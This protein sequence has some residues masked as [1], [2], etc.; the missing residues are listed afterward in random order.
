MK[1]LKNLTLLLSLS[2]GSLFAHAQ[3][4]SISNEL[5]SRSVDISN[6]KLAT[7]AIN[8]SGGEKSYVAKSADFSFYIDDERYD[9]MSSW[10]IIDH[11]Q[12]TDNSGM[13]L[14]TITLKDGRANP[15]FQIKLNYALYPGLPLIRKW[16]DFENIGNR[17]IKIE[18]LNVEDLVTT[19][20][21]V[22]SV[23]HHNYARMK[24]LMKYE[25]DW[26][27][28]VAVVHNTPERRG[29]ALGNEAPMVLK[30][31]TYHTDN[32]NIEIGL[33]RSDYKYPFRK[34]LTP[35]QK[36]SSPKTFICLYS[37]QEDGF[38]VVN[39]D[40]NK[41]VTNFMGNRVTNLKKKPTFVYNT[42]YPFRSFI[43]DKLVRDIAKSAAEC[44][45]QEFVIDDG[46]Q[47]NANKVSAN[48]NAGQNY[49]DWLVDLN[50]FPE[51]LKPTF[52]YIK[53]L[54]MKPGLWLSL[55]SA[56]SDSQVFKDHPE[57]FVKDKEGNI[58]NL[59]SQKINTMYTTS[60]GTEWV[61]YI[62]DVILRLVN[63]HG[64]EYAKLDLAIA[65]SA[66]CNDDS[67]T[68]SYST[69]D[70][71]YRDRP[72]SFIVFYENLL[73]LFDDLHQEAPDLFID[74]TFETAGKTQLMDYAISKHAEGN[75]LSNFE[76]NA[77]H[78]SLRVR[79]MAW[80]RSPAL[81][82]S[83]LVIGNMAMDDPN[84]EL[85]LKSLIGSLPIVLGDPRELSASEK[86]NIKKWAD[87]MS[88]MQDKHDYMKFRKDLKGFGEP[89]E[90]YWDGWQRL[91]FNSF[92]GGVFG[93]FRQG[94][95]E[96]SRVVVLDDLKPNSTY[97]VKEAPTGKTIYTGSGKSLME[98]GF[99]VT[100]T[101][102]YD[103]RIFE[104]CL[105]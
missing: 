66:Y 69:N 99:T 88:A 57:W 14:T 31:T 62:K 54:G 9:G 71:D 25:G 96:S 28:A 82:A 86:K 45:I 20:F 56:N 92:E 70:P 2:L 16:I 10:N 89:R 104:V 64:L 19:L 39:N 81:P 24:H 76:G 1:N 59:H 43:D 65:T 13:K 48:A 49:G 36:W 73:K 11:A 77:P 61:D 58:A 38:Q 3:T 68:G 72:E 33:T 95:A 87:W 30:R 6:N 102:E 26:D 12:T 53:S 18:N 27:D 8:L 5:V 47:Y 44:G 103:G 85:T 41:F 80:W 50:K 98:K 67:H 94:G 4:L 37:N 52:D 93:L 40:V 21:S 63:E 97:T 51:G 17:D 101:K 7:T 60:F 84:F 91:N 55:A 22:H 23:V 105:K 46:W 90:G 42:W 15:Q 35:K 100:M 74:C 75:W 32:N 83:S 34:W 78:G 29:I 79:Q